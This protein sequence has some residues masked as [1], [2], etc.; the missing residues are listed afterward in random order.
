MG[1]EV[2]TSYVF[3]FAWLMESLVKRAS[4]R[5]LNVT[6]HPYILEDEG[7]AILGIVSGGVGSEMLYF[8]SS[9]WEWCRFG[10]WVAIKRIEI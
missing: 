4:I 1:S 7:E 8:G 9:W 6:R 5:Y 2:D 3:G 10:A